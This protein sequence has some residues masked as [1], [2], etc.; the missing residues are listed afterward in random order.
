MPL[1]ILGNVGNFSF[2]QC[3]G[4]LN[5]GA[6]YMASDQ[7][8]NLLFSVSTLQIGSPGGAEPGTRQEVFCARA[9]PWCSVPSVPHV[10]GA[11]TVSALDP[12]LT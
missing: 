5:R 7:L 9:R 2:S 6:V 4:S 1:V 12:G 3:R 8:Q 11:L 10:V